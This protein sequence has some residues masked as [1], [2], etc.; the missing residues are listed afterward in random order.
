[1]FASGM[2]NNEVPMNLVEDLLAVYIILKN[3]ASYAIS[4]GSQA[5]SS[6][7]TIFRRR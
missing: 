4:Y 1:M 6:L 3:Y 2:L 5:A 7:V